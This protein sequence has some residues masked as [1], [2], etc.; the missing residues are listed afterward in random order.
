MTGVQ[1]CALP[2]SMSSGDW[3]D[4]EFERECSQ[5]FEEKTGRRAKGCFIPAD[6]LEAGAFIREEHLTRDLV[7]GVGSQGGYTVAEQLLASSFIDLLSNQA[8]VMAAGARVL[9][10]LVGDIDIPKQTGGATAYWVSAGS[11]ITESQ[12]AFGQIRMSPKTVG[13]L[14]D[15]TRRF[16]MQ[17]SLSAEAFVRMDFARSMALKIDEAAING[18]GS[19]GEPLGILNVSGIGSVTLNATNS[20]DWGDIVDLETAVLADNALTGSLSYMTNATI[21][22]NMKQTAKD[23]GSGLFLEIG[24]AS[25]RERV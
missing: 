9:D 4:A 14:T 24:R 8:L 12:Q 22:G 2:I 19:A 5:A 21:A 6:M 11:D 7:T 16:I 17:T 15:L 13:C 25:C 18:A 10:S 20:P 1:T 3:R 23:A